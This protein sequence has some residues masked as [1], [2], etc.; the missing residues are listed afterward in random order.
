[1]DDIHRHKTDD[2]PL[3]YWPCPENQV[4]VVC[5]SC[6]I[7]GTMFCGPGSEVTA[8]IHISWRHLCHSELNTE[9][10]LCHVTSSVTD[11]VTWFTSGCTTVVDLL[12]L[13][14]F[15]A[16]CWNR[17]HSRPQCL[18]TSGESLRLIYYFLLCDP[19]LHQRTTDVFY[20][21]FG[22]KLRPWTQGLSHSYQ[23]I[24]I[25]LQLERAETT[26]TKN[27]EEQRRS[28][29]YR[30]PELI[31]LTLTDTEQAKQ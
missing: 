30:A 28:D 11:Q 15:T 26:F 31:T 29:S 10:V 18:M 2:R 8:Q 7:Q 16:R 6:Q 5:D 25:R 20:C 22:A 12:S 13:R 4:V 14:Y 27:P 21:R 1:M 19:D 3:T 23:N 9:P 17:F 24:K